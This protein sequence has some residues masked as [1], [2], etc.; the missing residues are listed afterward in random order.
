MQPWLWREI[1]GSGIAREIGSVLQTLD[2]MAPDGEGVYLAAPISTGRRYYE[3]LACN[4]AA[5]YD[6]LI[7]AIGIE[8]YLRTVRWPNVADGE[9]IAADLRKRGVP[10]VINTGPLWCRDNGE[11][12]IWTSASH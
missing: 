5:T 10:Y 4:S 8:E 12:T 11:P 1:E 7:A 3:A 9:H 2:M 6:E